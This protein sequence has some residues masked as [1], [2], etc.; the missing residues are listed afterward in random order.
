V[1]YHPVGQLHISQWRSAVSSSG[2][3]AYHPVGQLHISQWRSAVSLNKGILNHTTVKI[4]PTR[5]FTF[6]TK[7][8]QKR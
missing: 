2:A 3:V 7:E 6:T 1:A 5:L 4:Q 8:F